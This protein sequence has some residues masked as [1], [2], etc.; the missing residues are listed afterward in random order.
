MVENRK[1]Y[2]IDASVALKWFIN[3]EENLE[4]ALKIKEKF[5]YKKIDLRTTFLFYFE[6]SNTIG[7]KYGNN[8]T[9]FISQLQQYNVREHK[10]NLMCYGLAFNL[11]KKYPKI[12]F[13]DAAYHALALSE[14]AIFITADKK[15]Y[16][17]V[18]KE[19]NIILLSNY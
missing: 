14:G 16:E 4:E 13:Y 18:K 3:D 10:L 19:G 8:A 12:S 6:I 17:K 1:T 7:R 5:I 11:M 15:Y 9:L 2:V